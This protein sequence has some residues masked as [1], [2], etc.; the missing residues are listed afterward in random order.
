MSIY[1]SIIK[2]IEYYSIKGVWEEIKN[3]ESDGR[4]I[5][6]YFAPYDY[7]DQVRITLLPLSSSEPIIGIGNLDLYLIN[8]MNKGVATLKFPSLEQFTITSIDSLK[9]DHYIDNYAI[10]GLIHNGTTLT[11]VSL[12]ES[13]PNGDRHQVTVESYNG[14]VKF[15]YDGELVHSQYGGPNVLSNNDE[16]SL[17]VCLTNGATTTSALALINMIRIYTEQ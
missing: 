3:Y 15:F 10:N 17:R 11:A 14:L 2:K 8:Y 7:G 13:I 1:N 9:V 4:S 16:L 12:G 6:L 5:K